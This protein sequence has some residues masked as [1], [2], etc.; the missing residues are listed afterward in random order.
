LI[1]DELIILIF[2]TKKTGFSFKLP[3]GSNF[4]ISSK[5]LRF[6]ELK[7]IFDTYKFLLIDLFLYIDY[8]KIVL[9]Y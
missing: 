3:K 7:E 1:I 6:K 8:L 9:T 4:E 2:S 5:N